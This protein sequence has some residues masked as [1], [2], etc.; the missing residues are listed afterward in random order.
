MTND[1]SHSPQWL[2]CD[3]DCGSCEAANECPFL[4]RHKEALAKADLKEKRKKKQKRIKGNT[5]TT[6]FNAREEKTRGSIP[7]ELPS[8]DD[9]EMEPTDPR[10]CASC[11]RQRDCARGKVQNCLVQKAVHADVDW[12]VPFW[13][14]KRI[15]HG[16]RLPELLFL[17]SQQKQALR[18]RQTRYGS[19][20]LR[21]FVVNLMTSDYA[22]CRLGKRAPS[23]LDYYLDSHRFPLVVQGRYN[24]LEPEARKPTA[25]EQRQMDMEQRELEKERRRKEALRIEEE[26]RE[27]RRRQREYDA[28]HAATPEEI[29]RILAEN[30]LPELSPGKDKKS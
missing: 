16:A 10:N 28:A 11:M 5:T 7:S 6:T 13:N 30:P 2:T 26:E 22:N 9:E 17:T 20:L 15:E 18:A 27:A 19:D 24:D 12:F 8:E 3:L 1:N 29:E 4:L 23:N 25:M 21:L 14:H